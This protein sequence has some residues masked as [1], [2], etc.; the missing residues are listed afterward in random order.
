[1]SEDVYGTLLIN[2]EDLTR[3]YMEKVFAFLILFF[4]PY[5]PDTGPL[6]RYLK[7]SFSESDQTW[8]SAR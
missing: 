5:S 8:Q 1:M 2:E 4:F 6:T 7:I 3:N